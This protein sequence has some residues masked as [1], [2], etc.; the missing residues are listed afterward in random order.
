M[1]IRIIDE[2]PVSEEEQKKWFENPTST[3]KDGSSR[4]RFL[5]EDPLTPEEKKKWGIPEDADMMPLGE[6][7]EPDFLHTPVNLSQ[8][9]IPS[10]EETQEKTLRK[11]AKAGVF[12]EEKLSPGEKIASGALAVGR[13]PLA[14][15]T[16]ALGFPII[17]SLIRK[18]EPEISRMADTQ[19]GA[20][21][22]GALN[23]VTVG[24]SDALARSRGVPLRGR[25]SSSGLAPD[26]RMVGEWTGLAVPAGTVLRPEIGAGKTIARSAITGGIYG[27]GGKTFEEL[28]KDEP[29]IKQALQEGAKAGAQ[30]ALIAPLIPIGFQRL[31]PKAQEAALKQANKILADI[32][33]VASKDANK[34][35]RLLSGQ[36]SEVLPEISNF[37]KKGSG[38][39]GFLEASSKAL[40]ERAK[41]FVPLVENASP[42]AFRKEN[43]LPEIERRLSQ[44]LPEPASRA[45]AIQKV[46]NFIENASPE[47][48]LKFNSQLNDDLIRFYKSATPEASADVAFAKKAVRD[49][50][51]DIIRN[52]ISESGADPSVYSK[53]GMIHEL[54]DLIGDNFRKE[55]VSHLGTMG[56]GVLSRLKES[57]SSLLTPRGLIIG[58]GKA[59]AP[60]LG[61]EPKRINNQVNRMMKS[62]TPSKVLSDQERQTLIQG[63]KTRRAD[64][65]K[66]AD[67]EQTLNRAREENLSMAASEKEL[68]GELSK[69]MK[70]SVSIEEA[71]RIGKELEKAYPQAIKEELKTIRG[72]QTP[73]LLEDYYFTLNTS[74]DPTAVARI[75]AELQRRLGYK[76]Y[77]KDFQE[78]REAL[79]IPQP[80]PGFNL[81][82]K[83]E[84]E[85]SEQMPTLNIQ[86]PQIP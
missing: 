83:R 79:N 82:R 25:E 84:L 62:F 28:Q 81:P 69:L 13:I 1:S 11:S 30:T 5:D 50:F 76:K 41:T 16:G 45:S 20:F 38:T 9:L 14:A 66:I 23:T 44:D 22:E 34:Q 18:A 49:T 51:S 72:R 58:T 40:K 24:A 74:E 63:A 7:Q 42:F 21:A 80:L 61:G 71:S 55:S 54:T 33:K 85:I 4:I 65:D 48:V 68:Q 39:E 8:P 53:Y 60:V 19:T 10:L 77:S 75:E 32:G 67:F 70:E 64:L 31:L 3:N 2:N 17:N 36:Y 47:N 57:D 15:A 37:F 26:A 6:P 52:T 46:S 56:K 86:P 27:G 35:E 78:I 73:S 12:P 59:F 43:L 29:D